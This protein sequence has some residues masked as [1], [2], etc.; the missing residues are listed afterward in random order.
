MFDK[1]AKKIL[2]DHY[3]K[4]GWK[5]EGSRVLDAA[6]IEYAKSK[7]FWFDPV[8]MQHD[9]IVE[10]L[11]ARCRTLTPKRV[12]DAFLASLSSRRL[13]MRSALGSYGFASNL[14][15]HKLLSSPRSRAPS[16]AEICPICGEF[17]LPEP[18][19]EDLNVLNF[20]RHKWGGVRHG[21]VRYAWFD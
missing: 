12:G 21:Q 11:Q 7:G 18:E 1:K 4:S 5:G 17:S 19:L 8:E 9:V 13:D 16:G 6:D 3:W 14:P 20:E 2:F 15:V 10:E